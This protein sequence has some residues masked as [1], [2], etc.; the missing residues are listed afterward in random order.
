MM[1]FLNYDFL[2]NDGQE[3][4]SLE[5]C[6][7]HVTGYAPLLKREGNRASWRKLCFGKGSSPRVMYTSS[8]APS[9][10]PTR[11]RVGGYLIKGGYPP[12]GQC[13]YLIQVQHDFDLIIELEEHV[14]PFDA[15][16]PSCCGLQLEQSNWLYCTVGKY[17]WASIMFIE[18]GQQ[19]DV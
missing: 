10:H 6:H 7:L 16:L 15:Q 18:K 2:E 19:S 12:Y 11:D 17:V 1:T 14:C 13:I 8:A 3:V 5:T 4:T 9:A